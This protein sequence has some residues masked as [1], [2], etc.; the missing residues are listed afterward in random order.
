[1]TSRCLALASLLFAVTPLVAE[2][3]DLGE[4]KSIDLTNLQAAPFATTN[5]LLGQAV[6]LE[7]FAHW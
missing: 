4:L 6:L 2:M 1:M 7:H 5:E 3:K